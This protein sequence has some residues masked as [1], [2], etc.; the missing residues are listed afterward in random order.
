M[1]VYIPQHRW[2]DPSGR[3]CL[4]LIL[5]QDN[6]ASWSVKTLLFTQNISCAQNSSKHFRLNVPIRFSNDT[7]YLT[8]RILSHAE[9]ENTRMRLKRFNKNHNI[10]FSNPTVV[11]KFWTFRYSKKKTK[12]LLKNE[13]WHYLDDEK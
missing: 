7:I 6:S 4:I 3:C 11:I 10:Y 12:K 2:R 1:Y 9:F 13:T 8:N 5:P